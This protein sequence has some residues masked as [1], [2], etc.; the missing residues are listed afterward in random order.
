MARKNTST[1]I[2]SE[3][4]G[5]PVHP[6]LISP[7]PWTQ[8]IIEKWRG[9]YYPKLKKAS[10]TKICPFTEDP[11]NKTNGVCSVWYGG[12]IQIICPNRFYYGKFSLLKKIS[13]DFL[14]NTPEPKIVSEVKLKGYG[15]IDW[16]AYIE[17]DNI[18]ADFIGIEVQAIDTTGTGH[19]NKA[20]LDLL[21]K[22]YFE[23][24]PYK[25]GMN[26]YNA[27]KRA[28]I[29]MLEKGQVFEKWQIPF[30]WIMQDVLF[31]FMK[32]KFELSS[33]DRTNH[34]LYG[35]VNSPE[36]IREGDFIIIVPVKVNVSQ[37]KNYQQMNITLHMEGYYSTNMDKLL[38]AFKSEAV[39][40]IEEFKEA[41]KNKSKKKKH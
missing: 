30:I 14:G 41:I 33:G 11:C 35:P 5:I 39:P 18:I 10:K 40:D 38:D 36:Q 31:D 6:Y 34:N 32:S 3:I 8:G 20:V 17:K 24:T 29:Q 2:P 19:L 22:G 9:V 7:S 16:V 25:F 15:N 21:N 13:K 4:F 1:N 23:N 28:F 37:P 27:I 26:T 12:K